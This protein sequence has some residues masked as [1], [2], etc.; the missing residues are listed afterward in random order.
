MYITKHSYLIFVYK[1]AIAGHAKKKEIWKNDIKDRE[2][3]SNN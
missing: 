2:Y 1:F 3:N